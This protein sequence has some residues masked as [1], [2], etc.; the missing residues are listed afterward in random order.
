MRREEETNDRVGEKAVKMDIQQIGSLEV[1]VFTL[2]VR[3][4][5]SPTI[6]IWMT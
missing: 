4:E 2:V 3:G 6:W 1:T 5:T